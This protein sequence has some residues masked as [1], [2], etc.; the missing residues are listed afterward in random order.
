LQ[1]FA[2]ST[3]CRWTRQQLSP[4]VRGGVQSKAAE[5]VGTAATTTVTLGD[6]D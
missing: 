2:G 6:I 3:I 5:G 1:V 4:L